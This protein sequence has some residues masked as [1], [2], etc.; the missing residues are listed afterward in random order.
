[1][2][3]GVCHVNDTMKAYGV[4]PDLTI[5]LYSMAMVIG[6]GGNLLVLCVV[7]FQRLQWFAYDIFFVN[8]M[9]ADLLMLLT[10]PA[11]IYYILNY[12][13]IGHVAC[14]GLSFVFYVPLF[15]HSD[16]IAAIAVERYQNLV[17]HKPVSVRL[18]SITCAVLWVTVVLVTS[19]YYIFRAPEETESC[20][21]GNYTWHAPHGFRIVMD[22]AINSWTL[23][24][25][26]G[27]TV[28]LS[29]KIKASSRGNR[30][31]NS[32]ASY[33]LDAMA[34]NMMFFNGLFNFIIFRDIG[35]D[36]SKATSCHYLQQE[37][38]FRMMSVALVFARPVVSPILYVCVSRKLLHSVFHLFMRIP[39]ETLDSEHAKLMVD[40]K[41]DNGEV[42]D[43]LPRECESVL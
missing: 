38:F 33:H 6:V 26:A 19:P 1:M 25:P 32:R 8:M 28:F 18:A 22:L 2:S 23:L 37:H 21:L 27:L 24:V 17:K 20:I 13:K 14:I 30:K 40:G 34:I 15:L 9:F 11:W 12:T 43:P 5:T 35:V 36:Y 16:L 29:I 7:Y 41:V 10:I 42:P 4:T 3:E 39:Y 31:L